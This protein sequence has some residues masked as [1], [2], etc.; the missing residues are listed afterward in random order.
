M[1][2]RQV[3]MVYSGPDEDSPRPGYRRAA[4]LAEVLAM[5]E[6]RLRNLREDPWGVGDG[7]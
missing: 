4:S 3:W 7:G 6:D 5:R 1:T 2:L